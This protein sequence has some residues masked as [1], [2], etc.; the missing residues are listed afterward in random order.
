MSCQNP[1][2]NP[3]TGGFSGD[4]VMPG[5]AYSLVHCCPQHGHP[6]HQK[7]NPTVQ[8]SNNAL[9]SQD[10]S[11]VK[12]KIVTRKENKDRAYEIISP[13]PLSSGEVQLRTTKLN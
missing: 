1:W 6:G 2:Q 11:Q 3:Q 12:K 10:L 7:L 13:R 8:L 5:E 9:T 4:R